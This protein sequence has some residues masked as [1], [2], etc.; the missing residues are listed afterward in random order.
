MFL[1]CFGG[2]I[3]YTKQPIVYRLYPIKGLRRWLGDYEGLYRVAQIPIFHFPPLHSILVL[4]NS[5][6]ICV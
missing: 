4:S 2:K 5:K 1:V 6:I 3:T